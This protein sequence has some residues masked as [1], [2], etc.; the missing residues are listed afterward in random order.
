MQRIFYILGYAKGALEAITIRF[1][2]ASA[3]LIQRLVLF[4]G[5]L[6][7]NPAAQRGR[8]EAM[9]DI[10]REVPAAPSGSQDQ[11]GQ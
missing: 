7:S 6:R 11:E 1:T 4:S 5:P 8:R 9:W 3:A 2:A 10:L